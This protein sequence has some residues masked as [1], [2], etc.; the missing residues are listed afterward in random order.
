[1]D[2]G[3]KRWIQENKKLAAILLTALL[4]RLWGIWHGFPFLY[5]GDELTV[6]NGASTLLGKGLNPGHFDWPHFH[7]YLMALLFSPL[8]LLRV[9]QSGWTAVADNLVPFYFLGRVITALMGVGTVYLTYRLATG[10]FSEKVGYLAAIFLGINTI[11][12]VNSQL[13]LIDVPMTFW[14]MLSFYFCW[15]ITQKPS[16][17]NYLLAGL[18][19]GLA[20]STKYN[21]GLG[22]L[23]ILGAHWYL[24]LG[25]KFPKSVKELRLSM[26]SLKTLLTPTY[27]LLV[28]GASS[29]FGFFVGTPFALLDYKTFLSTKGPE[30]ALWQFVH[31]G[32]GGLQTGI[33]ERFS[34]LFI[35]VFAEGM[36]PLLVLASV[37][38][39]FLVWR[40]NRLGKFLLLP[41]TLVYLFYT[42]TF[43]Y[44]PAHFFI[45]LYPFLSLLAGVGF[46]WIYDK[47][48]LF[49]IIP[50]SQERFY[51]RFL[52]VVFIF[53]PLIS[54]LWSDYVLTQKDTRTQAYEWVNENIPAGTGIVV[55]NDYEPLLD[56]FKYPIYSIHQIL[57][58]E[59]LFQPIY[60]KFLDRGIKYGVLGG[61]N[62][63][64]RLKSAKW[65]PK[66]PEYP[67]YLLDEANIVQRFDP[68][69]H[70]GPVVLI[71]EIGY[72]YEVLHKNKETDAPA[73][74]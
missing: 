10:I 49:L 72:D 15:K 28:A 53:M 17:R 66:E 68:K 69:G 11:H 38:G 24:H 65:D 55:G 22:V 56:K 31:V 50:A 30:G 46:Y 45:P 33:L 7:Y 54:T 36:G 8:V 12:V 3:L 74:D 64:E 39:L 48:R 6:M 61:Y 42:S 63:E 41:F 16:L 57:L 40:N 34:N 37:V 71:F 19:V 26:E 67:D 14:L 25:I 21:A 29:L 59:D 32:S 58:D 9:V 52:F 18:F 5:N 73:V 27:L 13:F 23:G 70:P 20:T 35:H 60:P 43:T 4:L 1:M 44:S 2:F 47:L 51:L 62:L